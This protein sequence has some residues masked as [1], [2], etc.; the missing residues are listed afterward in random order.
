MNLILSAIVSIALG[1]AAVSAASQEKKLT[2]VSYTLNWYPQAEH[3]GLYHAKATGIF[4]KYGL[5]VTLRPGG[6]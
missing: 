4:E 1:F 3:G 6:P 5:D 2:P